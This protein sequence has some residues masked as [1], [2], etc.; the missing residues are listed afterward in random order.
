[1]PEVTTPQTQPQTP[2]Q[3]TPP[4]SPRPSAKKKGGRQKVIK[5]LVALGVVVA[6]LAGLSYGIWYLVFRK[7]STV[8]QPQFQEAQIGTIQSVVQGYGTA[9]PKESAAITLSAAGTV[10]EVY[11]TVGQQ[12][13]A[14]D[15]LYTIDSQAA[16][17]KLQKAQ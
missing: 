9:V 2:G 15:P 17:D 10:Q 3:T 8:G 6:I 4:I 1:M 11:V 5:R 7:D 12:V 14:G 16:R 13:F